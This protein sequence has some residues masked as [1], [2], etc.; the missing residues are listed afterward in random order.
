[1]AVSYIIGET[2]DETD[3][4]DPVYAFSFGRE[5]RYDGARQRYLS[6]E[7]SYSGNGGWS[8]VSETWSDYDGDAIN[9]DFSVTL[10]PYCQV[11]MIIGLSLLDSVLLVSKALTALSYAGFLSTLVTT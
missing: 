11:C 8:T 4:E 5:F 6:A 10:A 3:P 1:M 9:G 7:L 2:C